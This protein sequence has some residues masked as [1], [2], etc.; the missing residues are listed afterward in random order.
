MTFKLS[1]IRIT[2]QYGI[3]RTVLSQAPEGALSTSQCGALRCSRH[4]LIL[5]GD[6]TRGLHNQ[7][8]EENARDRTHATT[9]GP[10]ATEL[11]EEAVSRPIAKTEAPP[12]SAH[13]FYG[14]VGSGIGAA[15]FDP[16]S[17]T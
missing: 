11:I 12:Q 7:H 5:L 2:V 1:A 8:A 17:F 6:Q 10:S 15:D 13:P 14:S 3:S 9:C 16:A 4:Q